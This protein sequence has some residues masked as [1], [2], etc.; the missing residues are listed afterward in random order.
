M[1]ERKPDIHVEFKEPLTVAPLPIVVPCTRLE[2]EKKKAER[3]E[4]Q[5][6]A[7]NVN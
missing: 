7:E 2:E 4:S 6:V 1:S 5:D 3:G